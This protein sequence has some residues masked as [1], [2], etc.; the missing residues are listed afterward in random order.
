[1][2]VLVLIGGGR[3]GIDLFQS[4]LDGHPQIM[5]F[6]HH[7]HFNEFW[8]KVKHFKEPSKILSIF[9]SDNKKC[10]DSRINKVERHDQLGENKN[11]LHLERGEIYFLQDSDSILSLTFDEFTLK[12]LDFGDFTNY[13]VNQDN[14]SF[15]LWPFSLIIMIFVSVLI[16]LPLSKISARQGRFSRVLPALLIFSVYTGMILSFKDFQLENF[17]YVIATHSIFLFFGLFMNFYVFRKV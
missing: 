13:E 17:R 7:F 10:F 16:S 1:M 8:K 5:Q 14:N 2:K 11:E 9:I 3:S 12:D 4:L 15:S 6:P